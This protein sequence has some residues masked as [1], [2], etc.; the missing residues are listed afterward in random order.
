MKDRTYRYFT[1]VPLWGFG[2]GLSYTS[3]KWSDVKLSAKKLT[4]GE[5]LTVDADVT[6]A[7]SVKGDAVSE[8]YLKG[9]DSPIHPL[10]ALIGFVR[11]PLDA[12]Q[13]QHIHV[14]IDPRSLSTV[15]A[16][17]K[18]S[19]EAG[20]YSIF[21]GGSQ[22]G[23]SIQSQ[24]GS[25]RSWE[26]KIC[27]DE[28]YASLSL[29]NGRSRA[30]V[31]WTALALAAGMIA[32][33]GAQL[34]ASPVPGIRQPVNPQAAWLTYS[35]VDAQ[36]VFP[37]ADPIPDTILRLGD[38]PVEA[39]AADEVQLGFEGMLHRVLR[40]DTHAGLPEESIIWCAWQ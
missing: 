22:P 23:E 6:N 24:H 5:P 40:L 2:Y 32:G 17:G 36:R 20:E 25:S 35:F 34:F 38:S 28:E 16:D 33:A 30:K 3:F 18:R 37:A 19:I 27:L 29:G 11:T 1:G 12:G 8:I 31:R 14:V 10:H 39:T 15:A 4:A 9:P 7:G 26:R 13:Q 21:V